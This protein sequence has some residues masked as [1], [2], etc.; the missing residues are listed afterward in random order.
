MFVRGEG[1]TAE[2]VNYRL[3]GRYYVVD[4][5]FAAAEL[6]LGERR[7]QVVRIIRTGSGHMG[8]AR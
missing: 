7:Q 2:L 6:R 1:G 4:R 3:R 8:N 5:L